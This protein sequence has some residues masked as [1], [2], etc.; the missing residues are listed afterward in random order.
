MKRFLSL[1]LALVMVLS[2]VACGGGSSDD[3]SGDGAASDFKT[4]IMLP[5][6]EGENAIFQM[7]CDGIRQACA[8]A[9]APEPKVVEGGGEWTSYG[10]FLT[11]LAAAQEYDVIFTTTDVMR[12]N[13]NETLKSFP[14]QKIVILDAD[15]LAYESK[16]EGGTIPA[17][18]WGMSFDL[19]QLGYLGGYFCGLV[20]QSDMERANDDLVVGLVT[21]DIYDAWDVNMKT[22]FT[23]GVKAANPDIEIITACIG[24]WVDPAKGSSVA[25]ALIAQGADIL[26]YTSGASAYGCVTEAA[27]QGCYAIPHDNNCMDLDPD[28]IIGAS[29][30][31]GYDAAYNAAKGAIEGTLEWGTGRNAGVAEGVISFTFDEANY[32]EKVPEDIRTAM[33]AAAQGL[34]DGS[35]DAHAAID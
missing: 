3:G 25:R 22:G 21:T 7:I 2:L 19:Y 23:N 10:K 30:V 35:I 14:D 28:T 29:L 1:I 8:D 27:T 6:T 13:V 11:S 16:F 26:Y 17:T 18:V 31:L 24:D 20:T 9:G 33:E 5:G 12:Y 4:A 32:M 15:L 34:A